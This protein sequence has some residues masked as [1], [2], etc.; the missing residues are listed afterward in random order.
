MNKIL[1]KFWDSQFEGFAP[2]AHNLKLEFK[3]RWVRFHSLSE[4]KRY[5][6]FESEYQEV[7]SRYNSL[8]QEIFSLQSSLLVL[9]PEYSGFVEPTNPGKELHVIFPETTYWCSVT[10]HEEDED[11]FY[12]HLHAAE[13]KLNSQEL[14]CLFRLVANDEVGNIIITGIESKAVFHPYDGGADV[15]LP[16]TEKR[17]EIKSK[18]SMWLS[19][20]PEGY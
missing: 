14:N 5:P 3:E 12:W 10:Q 20:H 8:L 16:T 9:L 1:T 4:S 2:V 19:L 6:D 13:V 7:L 11:A 15:I 18:F 17:N